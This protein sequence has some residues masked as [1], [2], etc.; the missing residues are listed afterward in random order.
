M[1]RLTLTVILILFAAGSAMTE[2]V[3]EPDRLVDNYR[4]NYP[5]MSMTDTAF[6]FESE[7]LFPE[8]Y[9]RPDSSALTPF[10]NWI[11]HFPI[12]HQYKPVGQWKGGKAFEAG[13]ISRVVHLPWKGP[14]YRDVAFPLRIMAEY[15]L[16]QHRENDLAI[17][18]R[19]GDTLQYP[20][21]LASKAAYSGTGAVKLIEAKPRE[22]S[23]V[24]YYRCLNVAMQQTD[25]R[26]LA[27]NGDS[28]RADQ[29]APGDLLIGHDEKG[30][31]G[32]VYFIMNMLVNDT[33]QRLYAIAT[34]CTD[35]CDFYI[36]KVNADRHNPWLTIERLQSLVAAYPE[37]GFFRLRM[38]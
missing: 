9:H 14:V 19:L 27:A 6:T 26:S 33:G 10:Q 21:W 7:F 36:P 24:E 22:S 8:G 12:W 2:E 34:G 3:T 20:R 1:I 38:E 25:Y 37:R 29:V 15:L 23:E 5:F 18:P 35:P 30:K 16:Y 31:R 17:V 4:R 28:I 32:H 13:Q 11:A